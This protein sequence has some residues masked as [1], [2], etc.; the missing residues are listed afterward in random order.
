MAPLYFSKAIPERVHPANYNIWALGAMFNS[1]DEADSY[2][3]WVAEVITSVINNN[4]EAFEYAY[5]WG[6]GRGGW[7]ASKVSQVVGSDDYFKKPAAKKKKITAK[8]R[9][10]VYERDKYRCKKCGTHIDLSVDHI[11][12]ESK[13]GK[14][15]LDNL[16][17]LCFPCN[18]RKG[19]KQDEA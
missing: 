14:T 16:Q 3:K 10:S 1:I 8:L 18:T 17:T 12:P 9:K 19:T 6:D 7:I 2:D 11:V 15:R 4:R 5:R 13:G